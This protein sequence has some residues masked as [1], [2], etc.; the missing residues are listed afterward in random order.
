MKDRRDIT[1][2]KIENQVERV[3]SLKSGC[4]QVKK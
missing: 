2:L 1:H 4:W 3:G